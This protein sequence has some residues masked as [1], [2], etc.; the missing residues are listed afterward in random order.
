MPAHPELDP[1]TVAGTVLERNTLML[2]R[3][4]KAKALHDRGESAYANDFAPTHTAVQALQWFQAEPTH[5]APFVALEVGKPLDPERLPPTGAPIV[6]TARVK[7]AGRAMAINVK[8]K[9]AF[10][11]VQDR[12]AAQVPALRKAENLLRVACGLPEREAD[13]PT[14]QFYF[15][16]DDDPETF[17]RLFKPSP[18][19]AWEGPLCDVGDIIGGEGLWFRTRT[20]EQSLWLKPFDGRPALRVLT[21]SVRPLPDKFHG[22]ADKETRLRQRYVDLVMNPEVREIFRKRSQVLAGVRRFLDER[23]YIE[24]ETPMMHALLGG[25]AA[26]PFRTHHNALDM[27]L[28]LRIAPEL[29]LKRLV[30]GGIERVYEIN[31][32]FRNEGLSQRHNPEFTMLEFYRAYATFFDLMD[33]VETLIAQLAQEVC[34]TTEVVWGSDK[35]GAPRQISLAA[36]FARVRIK[37]GLVQWGGIA[38]DQVGDEG[39]LRRRAA[40]LGV[41]IDAHAPL[42]KVQVE[43]F[44]AVAERHLI[45]PTF[46]WEYPAETSPLARRNDADP[47]VVDRFELFVGGIEIS[48]AFSELNDPQDQYLRFEHQLSQRAKGDEETMDLDED[49]VRA[50]EYGMPPAAGCGIGIDRLVMLLTGAEAIREVILFPHMRPEAT[51]PEVAASDS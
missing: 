39:V 8:G 29:H 5:L 43:L 15:S 30:V 32:N 24:V 28:Y 14:F 34:G 3:L 22:L 12:T 7:M 37:D 6:Q 45:Q 20:G 48:N 38:A 50:L 18:D 42:G 19:A 13:T 10:V 25:A 21:K 23:G 49:Y 1:A 9:V 26:R 51:T 33:E 44:E 41:H 27:P 40:E 47:S 4:T 35:Q 2:Q 31:R 17:D 16:R 11:R 36:P 46:V